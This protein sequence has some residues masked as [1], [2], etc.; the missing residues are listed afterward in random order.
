MTLMKNEEGGI[1]LELFLFTLLLSIFSVGALE[2]HRTYRKRFRAIIEHRN[3]NIEI[4]RRKAPQ[5]LSYGRFPD[6][7]DF[8]KPEPRRSRKPKYRAG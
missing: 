1:L 5:R 8:G 3:K 4:T 7:L 2:I 6:D